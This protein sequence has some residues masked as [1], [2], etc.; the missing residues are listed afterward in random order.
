MLAR[1]REVRPRPEIRLEEVPAPA[2]LAPHSVALAAE[3]HAD[4]QLGGSGGG[5][6]GADDGDD[7][8]GA[9]RFVLLYDPACPEPWGGAWRVVS[10]AR[11][12]LEP[13]L[14]TDPALGGVGWSW[15]Q[16]ALDVAGADYVAAAGTVT[17]VVSERFGGCG[18]SP[19]PWRWRSAPRG[20]RRTTRSRPIWR[21]GSRCSPPCRAC[22]RCRK[23]SQ[24]CQNDAPEPAIT[25][26]RNQFADFSPVWQLPWPR[27]LWGDQVLA[28]GQGVCG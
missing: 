19:T 4:R 8:V 16:D 24:S 20:P 27:V 21:P 11:A 23:A 18:A 14:S 26:H 10:F 6:G 2:R 25:T 3:V 9:G 12:Q 5:A 1:L 28:A 13:E 17:R 15:L 7:E 22:H